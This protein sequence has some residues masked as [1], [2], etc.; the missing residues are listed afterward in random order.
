MSEKEQTRDATYEKVRAAFEELGIEERAAFL[1]EAAAATLGRGL[2][3]AGRTLA[4]VLE[5]LFDAGEN[6]G[7]DG[8]SVEPEAPK[9]KPAARKTPAGKT[10]RKRSTKK[11]A[12]KPPS[13]DDAS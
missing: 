8:E 10:T 2:E 13:H 4:H 5:D 3:E 11:A 6:E 12:P 9:P 1:V 7:G